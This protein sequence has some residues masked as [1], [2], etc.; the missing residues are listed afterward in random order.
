MYKTKV[1]FHG[2]TCDKSFS[3]RQIPRVGEWVKIFYTEGW[4]EEK[5]EKNWCIGGKV[6]KLEHIVYDNRYNDGSWA[7]V[8]IV[9][10]PDFNFEVT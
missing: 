3:I 9:L 10:S 1:R 2:A 5:N 6:D 7:E 8:D 4:E